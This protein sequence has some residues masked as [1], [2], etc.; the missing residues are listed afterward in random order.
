MIKALILTTLLTSQGESFEILQSEKTPFPTQVARAQLQPFQGAPTDP[1]TKVSQ[2]FQ[3]P[4][5]MPAT[6]VQRGV[7]VP[8]LGKRHRF[9]L[10][11]IRAAYRANT[12]DVQTIP[13][14][15]RFG[16]PDFVPAVKSVCQS[17]ATR[18]RI[19]FG[20]RVAGPNKR[21]SPGRGGTYKRTVDSE[22]SCRRL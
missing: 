2:E 9:P 14:G 4:R 10:L 11:G 21:L 6:T 20:S 17:R 19:L 3:V 22:T 15:I 5:G 12:L 18:R 1:V 16:V 8:H 7:M 13:R